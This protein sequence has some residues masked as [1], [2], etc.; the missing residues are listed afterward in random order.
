MFYLS[1]C[2]GHDYYWDFISE[3]EKEKKKKKKKK[4]GEEEQEEGGEGG[5]RITIIPYR[6]VSW[7]FCWRRGAYFPLVL[8]GFAGSRWQDRLTPLQ[9]TF[10]LPPSLPPTIPLFL[11]RLTGCG[12][13]SSRFRPDNSRWIGFSMPGSSWLQGSHV[14]CPIG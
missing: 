8:F 14:E 3:G 5:G 11:K 6:V 7:S 13:L 4:V 1:Y 10:S 2:Y 12:F 9:P